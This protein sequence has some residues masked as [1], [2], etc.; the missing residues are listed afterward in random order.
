MHI[1]SKTVNTQ[2]L[3]VQSHQVAPPPNP[4]Y[5]TAD[6]QNKAKQIT[7]ITVI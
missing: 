3:Y 5:K 4:L 2:P 6:L 1:L 7:L